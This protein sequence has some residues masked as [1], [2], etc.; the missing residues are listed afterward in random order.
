MLGFVLDNAPNLQHSILASSCEIATTRAE[1][2]SP[3]WLLVSSNIL[4]QAH[5]GLDALLSLKNFGTDL[6]VQEKHVFLILHLDYE[7]II[8]TNFLSFLFK[9]L[10]DDPAQSILVMMFDET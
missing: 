3:D 1:F 9:L 4:D 6:L 2:G 7:W 10:L 5:V 8:K